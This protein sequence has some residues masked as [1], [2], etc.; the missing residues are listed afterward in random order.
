MLFVENLVLR[1]IHLVGPT[2]LGR[3]IVSRSIIEYIDLMYF[4]PYIEGAKCVFFFFSVRQ[5][6]E[7]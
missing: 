4:D 6:F 2:H 5:M 1:V 7:E 3:D